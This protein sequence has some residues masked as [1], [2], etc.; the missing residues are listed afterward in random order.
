MKRPT[1]QA[2]ADFAGHYSVNQGIGEY[3]RGEV[4]TNTTE[5]FFSIFKR[6]MRGI[7]QHCGRKHLH[8]YMAEFDFRYSNR[9]APGFSD[10][11]RA[12]AALAGIVRK[13]L[14]YE[15]VGA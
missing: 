9:I 7:Y 3:G 14:T 2:A 1:K 4:H 8:R 13:R 5:G 15:T 11:A 10:A 6:G 12:D